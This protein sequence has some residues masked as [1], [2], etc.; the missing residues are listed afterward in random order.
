MKGGGDKER[1]DGKNNGSWLMVHG[2][3]LS[4][5]K[6]ERE[7]PPRSPCLGGRRRNPLSVSPRGEG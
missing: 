6:N 4:L 7:R 5:V 1:G 3:G 2:E